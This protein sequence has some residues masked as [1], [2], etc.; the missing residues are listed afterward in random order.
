MASSETA[1]LM[2][3]RETTPEVYE[4]MSRE[5]LETSLERWNAW[6]DTMAATGKLHDGRP[7]ES[8]GRRVSGKQGKA[9]VDGPFTEAKELVGGY[10]LLTDLTLEAVTAF[11]QA[12]PS[13]E[14]GMTVEIRPVAAT[15]HLA[16]ALGWETMRG[17][18]DA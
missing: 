9:V 12:C 1:Y 6:V 16:R 8:T 2:L 4:A 18:A 5:E 15:C 14:F 11:A 7:L 10:F 17:P 13:L 3:V